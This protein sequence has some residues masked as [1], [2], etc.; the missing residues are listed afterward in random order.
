MA[1]LTIHNISDDLLDKL[2][3]SAIERG[4]TVED[5]SYPAY[6]LYFLPVERTRTGRTPGEYP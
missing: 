4:L 1:T 5:R 2:E 3:R 6:S